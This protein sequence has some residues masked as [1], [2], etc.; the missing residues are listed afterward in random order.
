VSSSL[1][2]GL[3]Y[4]TKTVFEIVSD[5]VGAQG[6]VCGGGRYDGLVKQLGGPSVPAVGFG[7]GMERLLLLLDKSANPIIKPLR[8]ELYIATHGDAAKERAFT[9]TNNLRKTGLTVE[10]DHMGRSL[11]AQFKYAD[12]IQV[13]YVLTLGEEEML[14]GKARIRRMAD[15]MTKSSDLNVQAILNALRLEEVSWEN[16]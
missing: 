9:L 13:P 3:D 1:V 8:F 2:R 4:Y 15:G 14:A 6:T 12:K 10:T 5:Y 7:M 11:K 16:C